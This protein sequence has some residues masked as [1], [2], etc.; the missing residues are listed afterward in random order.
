MKYHQPP[1]V[2]YL[3]CFENDDLPSRLH[4]FHVF[5]AVCRGNRPSQ[6]GL[7]S[8]LQ[9]VGGCCEV[10]RSRFRRGKPRLLRPILRRLLPLVVGAIP[11]FERARYRVQRSRLDILRLQ[12]PL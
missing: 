4:V 6:N 12:I 1:E 8:S 7:N 3:P 9:V 2:N 11:Y 5:H 10:C